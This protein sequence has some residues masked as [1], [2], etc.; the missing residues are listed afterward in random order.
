MAKRS[1]AVKAYTQISFRDC[2]I[3]E[4]LKDRESGKQKRLK[5]GDEDKFRKLSRYYFE[6]RTVTTVAA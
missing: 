1:A 2:T 6:S 4:I 5:K 3:N